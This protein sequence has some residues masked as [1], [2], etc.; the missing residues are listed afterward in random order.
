LRPGGP[1][2]RQQDEA[3][4]EKIKAFAHLK[5]YRKGFSAFGFPRVNSIIRELACVS[6]KSGKWHECRRSTS[7]GRER[8]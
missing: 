2:K 7:K 8:P 1:E 4:A 5:S 6:V 3:C